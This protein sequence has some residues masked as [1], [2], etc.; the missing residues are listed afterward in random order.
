VAANGATICDVSG[1]KEIPSDLIAANCV[2]PG[3]M[4]LSG[5]EI[6]CDYY[7]NVDSDRF[8]YLR[9]PS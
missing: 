8:V 5:W 9:A 6:V 1:G 7:Q 2:P 3:F 4:V